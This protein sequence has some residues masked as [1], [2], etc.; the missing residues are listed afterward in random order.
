MM[1]NDSGDNGR[2]SDLY[3]RVFRDD[4]EE[5][6]PLKRRGKGNKG[7]PRSPHKSCY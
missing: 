3:T 2:L 6:T 5:P 4:E 1:K 7:R